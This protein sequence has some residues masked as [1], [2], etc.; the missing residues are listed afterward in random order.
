[1][2]PSPQLKPDRSQVFWSGPDD[3]ASTVPL[4]G[5]NRNKVVRNS[6]R[7]NWLQLRIERV[8]IL[9]SRRL[10]SVRILPEEPTPTLAVNDLPPPSA[11][12]SLNC[13]F[14]LSALVGCVES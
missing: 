13:P 6:R 3:C 11:R 1:M 14:S 12:M 10:I 7:L 9:W 2:L 4:L 5:A 8:R